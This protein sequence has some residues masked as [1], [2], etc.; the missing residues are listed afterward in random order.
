MSIVSPLPQTRG[1]VL[2]NEHRAVLVDFLESRPADTLYLRSLVHE[3]GV[4]RSPVMEHGRFFGGWQGG[5]LVSVAF[6]GNSRNLTTWGASKNLP[7]VLDLALMDPRRPRLFVGPEAHAREV[8][9]ALSRVGS[10][11]S[12]DRAQVYCVL[13]PETLVPLEP[14]P[15]VPAQISA[16]DQVTMAQATMT[17]EDLLIPRSQIDFNRLQQI[18]RK[19]ISRGKVWVVMDGPRLI[20]KT[21]ESAR[22]AEGILVGGVFTDPASRGRGIAARAMASWGRILFDLGLQR[23]ALHVNSK[24]KAAIHA[25]ERA[26]FKKHSMLRLMLTY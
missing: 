25:Y 11:P 26:G 14:L 8:R 21:E 24:N 23:V 15:I 3:F 2:E 16:I 12:L 20:F 6:A 17:E 19:R 9:R 13:T 7:P 18:S 22:S 5:E 1:A 4:S 10:S